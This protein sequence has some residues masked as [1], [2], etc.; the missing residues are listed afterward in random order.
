MTLGEVADGLGCLM[1]VGIPAR[2]LDVA[3]D[4]VQP[5]YNLELDSE[6]HAYL[7]NGLIVYNLKVPA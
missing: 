7:A 4:G 3:D 5:V 1:T 2:V 6:P